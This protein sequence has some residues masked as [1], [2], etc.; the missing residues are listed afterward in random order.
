MSR[1]CR[2]AVAQNSFAPIPI[3]KGHHRI[4]NDEHSAQNCFQNDVENKISKNGIRKICI[5]S[6]KL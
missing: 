3:I 2:P 1:I 5:A 6:G 4:P